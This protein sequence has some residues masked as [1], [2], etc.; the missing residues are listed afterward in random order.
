M[1][2]FTLRTRYVKPTNTRG[3]RIR[4]EVIGVGG[5]GYNAKT[6]PRN[7]A[8]EAHS[9]AVMEYLHALGFDAFRIMCEGETR[10]GSGKRYRVEVEVR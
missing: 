3:S 10:T 5:K 6:L 4:V 9:G 1:N 2:A 8:S 7:Y